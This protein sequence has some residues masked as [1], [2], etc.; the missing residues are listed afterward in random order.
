MRRFEVVK[1]IFLP[2]E[3]DRLGKTDMTLMSEIW[4][5]ALPEDPIEIESTEMDT[6]W[7]HE[8]KGGKRQ[9]ASEDETK[10]AST[11]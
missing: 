11:D 8:V 3:L 6:R 5:I 10:C 9:M 2:A 7:P 4:N 1:T